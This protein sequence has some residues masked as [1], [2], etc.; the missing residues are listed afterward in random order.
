MK[1]LNIMKNKMKF[2]IDLYALKSEKANCN[3]KC[4]YCHLDYFNINSGF[5]AGLKTDFTDLIKMCQKA[6]G[7]EDSSLKLHYSGRADPLLVDKDVFMRETTKIRDQF[8]S[9]EIVMTTNGIRLYEYSEVIRLSG[10]NKINV[11]HHNYSGELEAKVFKGIEIVR[12]NKMKIILNVVATEEVLKNIDHFI[13]LGDKYS[14]S[15]K[16]FNLISDDKAY[17]GELFARFVKELRGYCSEEYY[18]DTIKNRIETSSK[19]GNRISIKLAEKFYNRPDAC[20]NCPFLKK[21]DES[22]WDTIR[23]TPWYIKPCGV[24]K[25]NVYFPGEQNLSILKSKLKSGGKFYN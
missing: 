5:D 10:I 24:R 23:L 8:S 13:R 20:Q 17:S 6:I 19:A 3:L 12:N 21:C 2:R 15:L 25:D 11:S 7:S 9:A 16:F 4:S 22:C 1:N 14:I 18:E